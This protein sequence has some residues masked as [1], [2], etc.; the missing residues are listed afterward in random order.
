MIRLKAEVPK[1]NK[2]DFNKA[3]RDIGDR[4]AKRVHKTYDELVVNWRNDR[5]RDIDVR[6]LFVEK[7]TVSARG[8]KVEVK[9]DSL[10]YRFVDLGTRPHEINPRPENK[11]G[12]LIF[13]KEF[14]PKTTPQ[15]LGYD[16][17][18]GKNWDGPFIRTPHV[19]EHP[20]IKEPRMFEIP[21]IE[22]QIPIVTRDIVSTLSVK[23]KKLVET[24]T[25]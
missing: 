20:G 21:I 14:T 11:Y 17:G 23:L 18:A 9:T 7:I 6:P 10:K 22:E 2:A 12:L 4:L 5:D 16:S 15:V 1:V 25:L 13:P 24:E 3:L 19:E 8:M